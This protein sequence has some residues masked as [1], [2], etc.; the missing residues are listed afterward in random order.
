MAAAKACSTADSCLSFPPERTLR[1][2]LLDCQMT[3]F[4]QLIHIKKLKQS[5]LKP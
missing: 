5:W 3:T 1:T 2:K 4:Y